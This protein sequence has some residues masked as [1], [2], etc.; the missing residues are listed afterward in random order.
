MKIV[1]WKRKETSRFDI[2][3]VTFKDLFIS[4]ERKL[5]KA[6]HPQCIVVSLATIQAKCNYWQYIACLMTRTVQE[7]YLDPNIVLGTASQ[8][9]PRCPTQRYTAL[10]ANSAELTNEL[11]PCSFKN[12]ENRSLLS[13]GHKHRFGI[14]RITHQNETVGIDFKQ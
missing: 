9:L 1:R 7:S 12:W 10:M 3:K 13:H 4:N 8:T 2:K 6:L 14:H 11:W 5:K